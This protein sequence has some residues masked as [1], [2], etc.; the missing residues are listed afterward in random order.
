ML[1]FSDYWFV[2]KSTVSVRNV[3]SLCPIISYCVKAFQFSNPLCYVCIWLQTTL[4]ILFARNCTE[5]TFTFTFWGATLIIFWLM[6]NLAVMSLSPLCYQRKNTEEK[7][8]YSGRKPPKLVVLCGWSFLE[9]SEIIIF[10]VFVY[11]KW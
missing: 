7:A 5:L 4:Y 10:V 6:L 3:V 8:H 2:S 9:I 1:F 11:N